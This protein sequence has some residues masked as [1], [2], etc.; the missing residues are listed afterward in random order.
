MRFEA[1]LHNGANTLSEAVVVHVQQDGRVKIS[2][3]SLTSPIKSYE[4]EH[5]L[6]L[7]VQPRLANTPRL[8]GLPEGGQLESVDNDSIDS[9]QK[10]FSQ[11]ILYQ[12]I[13]RLERSWVA[14]LIGLVTTAVFFWGGVT[15][16]VPAVAK[17]VAHAIPEEVLFPL[18]DEVQAWMD[19][20]V[21]EPSQ[22]SVEKQQSLV[23]LFDDQLDEGHQ[24][25]L[26]FRKS[27]RIGANALALP[28]NVIILTDELVALS[29]NNQQLLAVLA[30]EIG[31][32]KNQHAIRRLLQQAGLAAMFIAFT[33]DV[34]SISSMVIYLPGLLL[35]LGYSRDFEY[36]ADEY[37]SDYMASNNIDQSH[38]IEILNR[39]H[40]SHIAMESDTGG[41]SE[42][43]DTNDS[44]ADN[45]QRSTFDYLSTHPAVESRIE[46]IRK[47]QP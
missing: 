27:P 9:L 23:D 4:F 34:S 29:E 17:V 31:H 42:N 20:E 46:R 43:Q 33:G 8:I 24:Y 26:L 14:V 28:N 18:G 44:E 40:E 13:D 6:E 38:L 11:S 37:A 30:H 5:W 36:E 47:F 12:T 41:P 39:L 7:D 21:F 45:N 3:R 32:L 16:G 35:E 22:L 2:P 15:Y 10:A 19:E 25:H 1:V